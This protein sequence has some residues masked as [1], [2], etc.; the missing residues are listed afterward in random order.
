MRNRRAR[1]QLGD[2]D[3][4]RAHAVTN[5]SNR[6]R[7][8]L[9]LREGA[10]RARRGRLRAVCNETRAPRRPARRVPA[11]DRRRRRA[12]AQNAGS[13][14]P[15]GSSI[16]TARA[17]TRPRQRLTCSGSGSTCLDANAAPRS[18][19][20][21]AARAHRSPDFSAACAHAPRRRSRAGDLARIVV[22]TTAAARAVET[23]ARRAAV[24]A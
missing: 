23:F 3:G 6:P 15:R 4:T 16:S 21:N 10:R 9:E 5:G 11:R 17:P 19:R 24:A 18:N 1:A 20:A 12:G 14:E 13:T 8:W 22:G 7:D 2:F